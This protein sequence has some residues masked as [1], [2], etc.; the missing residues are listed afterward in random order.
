MIYQFV[1]LAAAYLLGIITPGPSL[2]LIIQNGIIHSRNASYQACAGIVTGIAVQA[3]SILL[4]L[5]MIEAYPIFLQV[6][7]IFC[8]LFLVFL[9]AKSIFLADAFDEVKIR[10]SLRTV[11]K[12]IISS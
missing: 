1:E 8:A 11:K 3:G 2:S 6:L 9:G 7:K 12:K 10:N 5:D 4:C